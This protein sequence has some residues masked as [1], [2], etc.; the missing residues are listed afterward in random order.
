MVFDIEENWSARIL[1]LRSEEVM[2]S[3]EVVL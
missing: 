1:T 2:M 3:G